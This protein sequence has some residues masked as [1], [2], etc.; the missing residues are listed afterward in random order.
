MSYYIYIIQNKINNKIYV[1][2]TIEPE[3]RWNKHKYTAKKYYLD[4]NYKRAQYIH[5]AMSKYGINNFEF[6]IIEKWSSPDEV[7]DAE[8]FWI[9]FLK[10]RNNNFGYNI[11]KGGSGLGSGE[12][13]PCFGKLPHNKL[14]SL[15][16][17]K[18]IYQKYL[19]EKLSIT[20]LGKKYNCSAACI[21]QILKRNNIKTLGNKVLS[22]GRR[23]S[24]KTEFKKGQR[25][26]NKRFTHKQELEICRMYKDGLSCPKIA[27]QL[28]CHRTIIQNVVKS[29]E[30]QF[31]SRKRF[32]NKQEIEIYEKYHS[33]LSCI[34]IAKEYN[35]SKHTIQR[36][37]K[38]LAVI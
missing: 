9:S 24:P 34:K 2:Q 8:C 12:D 16:Q 38:R 19:K 18:E 7:D 37:I 20:D 33:G 1:G 11:T 5:R 30:I 14:F 21:F 10:T 13:H 17:E 6:Q 27:K 32:S 29:N 28:N 25:P 36:L 35:C 31:R 22:K 4:G 23:Y 26:H 3:N 15:K